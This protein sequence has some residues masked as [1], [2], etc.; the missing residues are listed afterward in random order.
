M[1]EHVLCTH[2]RGHLDT[3]RILTPFNHG[4]RSKHSCE[5]QLLLT[6]HDLLTERDK[7]KRV[8]VIILDFSKAF[9]TVPHK[10]LLGKLEHYGIEGETLNWITN[11]LS[12]RKQTVVVDGEHS[13]EADVLSGVPQGTVPGPLL[14]LLHINDLPSVIDPKTIIRLFADDCLLYQVIESAEDEQQLQKDLDALDVWA[15]NWGMSFNT[16]KCYTMPVDRNK[17]QTPH[18][19]SLNGTALGS[20]TSE[21]YLG[22]LISQNM[23]WSPHISSVSTKANQKLGFLKRN[24]KGSPT[25]IK[26]LAYISIVRSSLEYASVIW[27]PHLAKDINQL[28]GVQRKAARWIQGD[29]Q[30]T[31]SVSNMLKSL[32]LDTLE[33]RRRACRLAFMYKILRE[34]VAVSP[35]DM[36]I[37]RNPRAARGLCTQDKLIVPRCHTTELQKHFVAR[38]VPEWNRLL[39]STTSADSV[40][41]FK[42]RL[43]GAVRHP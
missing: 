32:Q 6:T 14:F 5:T 16:K 9:D 3:H 24:L 41:S 40:Q 29:H 28:E 13:K 18:V 37:V 34:D 31:S 25:D 1:M 39:Q 17:S 36:Y 43:A 21:K 22:V 30:R 15:N 33:E 12:G 27:D 19:Y 8:D 10:R 11:F 2:I 26:K 7:G 20:V 4:F 42:G 35:S 23:S 38:T